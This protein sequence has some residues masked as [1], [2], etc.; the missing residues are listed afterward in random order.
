MLFYLEIGV[1]KLTSFASSLDGFGTQGRRADVVV[2][3]HVNFI[4]SELFHVLKNV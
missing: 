3:M 1:P 4:K 2:G